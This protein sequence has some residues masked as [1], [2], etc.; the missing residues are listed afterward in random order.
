MFYALLRKKTARNW[1]PCLLILAF[2]L[3]PLPGFGQTAPPRSAS[4]ISAEARVNPEKATIGDIVV[5]SLLVRHDPGIEPSIPEFMPPKGLEFVDQGT[6]PPAKIDAQVIHEFW[7]RLRA[8]RVG[9]YSL[10]PLPIS[11]TVSKPESG[12]DK[13]PGKITVPEVR[14]EIQSI[15]H[16]QGEPTDIRDIKPIEALGRDWR[17]IIFAFLGFA[18]A[19]AVIVYL[20]RRR[21]KYSPAKPVSKPENLSPQELA[22]RELNELQAKGL[23][24]E[25]RIREYYFQLSEIFR[26]YLGCK[27]EFPASDWTTEEIEDYLIASSQLDMIYKERIVSILKST[28]LVK[29]AKAAVTSDANMMEEIVIFIQATSRGEEQGQSSPTASHS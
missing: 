5:Y 12:A 9:D 4:P 29:F 14:L 15:L 27:Y 28:D 18:L 19:A 2:N 25:G 22:L 3:V 24:A 10:P 17:P 11:F 8:D 1:I 13:I 23:L 7:F 6:K 20:W 16:L 26:R 21:K